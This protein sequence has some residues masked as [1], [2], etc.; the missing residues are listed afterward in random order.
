MSANKKS[1]RV[2]NTFQILKTFIWSWPINNNQTVPNWIT[3]HYISNANNS[4]I[5]EQMH[6]NIFKFATP[7]S[8]F[9]VFIDILFKLFYYVVITPLFPSRPNF[10]E[11]YLRIEPFLSLSFHRELLIFCI[12]SIRNYISSLNGSSF[13]ITISLKR[14]FP[15]PRTFFPL[16]LK[17]WYDKLF[18]SDILILHFV[19]YRS[20]LNK[21]INDRTIP[22]DASNGCGNEYR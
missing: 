17:P 8:W 10:L 22:V 9:S 15:S 12:L 16:K 2:L 1:T 18:P 6:C 3:Q 7:T 14:K 20:L 11:K 21:L 13:I 19:Q 5:K 4:E